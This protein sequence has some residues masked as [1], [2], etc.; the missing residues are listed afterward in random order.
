MNSGI[1]SAQLVT[2]LRVTKN[3]FSFGKSYRMKLRYASYDEF[4][5]VVLSQLH[6]IAFSSFAVD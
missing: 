1:I 3:M 6:L 5:L 2:L 4:K